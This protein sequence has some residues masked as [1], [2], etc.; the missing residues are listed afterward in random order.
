MKQIPLFL[1]ILLI[2][3]CSSPKKIDIDNKN[4]QYQRFL[5]EK[6]LQELKGIE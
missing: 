6:S 4:I 2:S 3:G 5:S 1:L